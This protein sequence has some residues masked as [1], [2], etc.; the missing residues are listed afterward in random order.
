MPTT[1]IEESQGDYRFLN[2]FWPA[3]VVLDGV[4]YPSVEHAYQAAKT[5]NLDDRK[6][7]LCCTHGEAKRAGRALLLRSDWEQVRL[8]IMSDLV[9]QKFTNNR[10][11]AEKLID[12]GAAEL[13]EGNNWNDTFWGVCRGIGDNNLGKILTVVRSQLSEGRNETG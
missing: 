5:L 10:I 9:K 3:S 4:S 6:Q 2:N 7:F 12:T 13:I 1:K 8:S 11:L